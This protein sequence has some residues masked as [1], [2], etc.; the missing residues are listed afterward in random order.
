M[1]RVTGKEVRVRMPQSLTARSGNLQLGD[2]NPQLGFTVRITLVRRRDQ[3][4]GKRIFAA[5]RPEVA[6]EG[7]VRLKWPPQTSL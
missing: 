4:F 2:L 6:F 5:R 3:S 7:R 1:R